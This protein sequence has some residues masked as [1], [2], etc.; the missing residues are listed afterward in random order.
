MLLRLAQRLFSCVLA[1]AACSSGLAEEDAAA[2]PYAEK[3]TWVAEVERG[4]YFFWERFFYRQGYPSEQPMPAEWY[5]P[6]ELVPGSPGAPPRVRTASERV[7]TDGTLAVLEDYAASRR[8][9]LLYVLHQGEVDYV[10]EGNG[11]HT[12][13]LVPI[14]SITWSCRDFWPAFC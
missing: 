4:D 2:D 9:E 5:R 7:L 8:T 13:S 1:V 3:R 11:S 10:F 6:G 14:R 12:G